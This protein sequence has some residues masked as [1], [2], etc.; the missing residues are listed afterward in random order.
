MQ[1]RAVRLASVALMFALVAVLFIAIPQRGAAGPVGTRADLILV[2]GGQ[3]DMKTR[4]P[5][6]AI[7]ND[8]WTSDVHGRIYDGV[9]QSHPVTRDLVPYIV[10]GVDTDGDGIFQRDEY[11]RFLRDSV[12]YLGNPCDATSAT[13]FC[14]L[15]VTAFY[16]FNGVYFHDD[17]QVDV[18]DM[19]FTYHLYA[20]NARFNT[21]LR[22]LFAAG[23]NSQYEDGNRQ[24]NIQLVTPITPAPSDWQDPVATGADP[25][26][27]ASVRYTLNEPFFNFY[28]STLAVG[29]WPEHLWTKRGQIGDPATAT[30][31]HG[32]FGCAVY[33]GTAS[34]LYLDTTKR[35][36]GIPSSATDLPLGCTSAYV[37]GLAETWAPTDDQVIGMGPFVFDQWIQGQFARVTTYQNFYIGRDYKRGN[38]VVDPF[39][40][41]YI[42]LPTIDGILFK[43][44]R[45]TTLGVLALGRGEIDFY[46]WNI[47]AEFVPDMIANTN[48]KVEANPE[49]GFFYMAYNLRRQPWGSSDDA[50]DQGPGGGYWYRQ[51]VSHLVDK[52]AIVQ[53]LLQN[54]GVIGHGVISPANTFWYNDA[55]PKP[56][57]DPT[58]AAA[59]LNA[60]GW[61]TDPPGVCSRNTPSGCR[62]LPGGKGTAVY[63]ILTPQADYDPVRAAAGQLIADSMQAVGINV[64]S[65][66]LAFGEIVSRIDARNFDQYILGWRIG[67]TDPD[68]MFSFWHSSNA[69]A[70]QN[71]PGYLNDT[72]DDLIERSRAELDRNARQQLIFDAQLNLADS[73]PYEVLYFRTNIEGYRQDRF[74]NWTVTAGTIW[75]FWSLMGI[76]PPSSQRLVPTPTLPSAVASGGTATMTVTVF[77]QNRNPVNGANVRLQLKTPNTGTLTSGT[78]DVDLNVTTG[79]SGQV[80]A[81]FNAPTVAIGNTPLVVLIDVTATH[82]DFP[83]PQSRTAQIT[84]FPEDVQFLAFTLELPS[85]DV[86]SG[87]GTLLLEVSVSDEG[88]VPVADADVDITSGDAVL[89]VNPAGGASGTLGTITLSAGSVTELTSVDVTVNATKAGYQSREVSFTVTIL[90]G[91]PNRCPSGQ[92]W[93]AASQSCKTLNPQTPGLEAVVLIAL[94][95]VMG[96]VGVRARRRGK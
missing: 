96:A 61:G 18:Y 87:G 34:G 55:I 63:E 43:I 36:Q 32:D 76:R 81:N 85:G 86:T 48:I 41:S 52:K 91:T 11:G 58:L 44:Y 77:D 19:L 33:P 30:N 29:L 3:D 67:G 84:V 42:K 51:A 24:L 28:E 6:P 8:V 79:S 69:A 7:A 59:I 23:T 70:G 14:A 71:Y 95:G 49:P 39:L 64:V 5:L 78:T 60:N 82:A 73:R 94:V 16:D 4:N 20:M 21:D 54:F 92:Y 10:K 15:T 62:S 66:P 12:D 31:I 1:A 53:N 74:V 93:D 45:S 37:Y 65:T 26:L 2:V 35:G 22:V 40:S 38:A 57:P 56:L 80:A 17:V 13:G 90:R 83:D 9:L 46:H 72:F 25:A 89:T 68:Y 75:G 27:R 50:V 47:P 88:G